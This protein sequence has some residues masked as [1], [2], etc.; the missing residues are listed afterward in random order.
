M[1]RRLDET[2]KPDRVV[3]HLRRMD[4]MRNYGGADIPNMQIILQPDVRRG[5][6]AWVEGSFKS[7]ALTAK[8]FLHSRMPK[9]QIILRQAAEGVHAVADLDLRAQNTS[10]TPV[11]T[12]D[13]SAGGSNVRFDQYVDPDPSIAA[14]MILRTKLSSAVSCSPPYNSVPGCYP[15]GIGSHAQ[16]P[17][18]ARNCYGA[19]QPGSSHPA[20]V[21]QGNAPQMGQV[22]LQAIPEQPRR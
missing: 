1:Q 13:H 11:Q 12:I 17:P 2:L 22:D 20:N 18:P 16:P 5:F 8:M 4:D 3:E 21:P 15:Q 14:E 19:P 6:V 10:K 7:K 9:D